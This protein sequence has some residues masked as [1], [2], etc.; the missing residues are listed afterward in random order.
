MGG[1]GLAIRNLIIVGN[2][3]GGPNLWSNGTKLKDL[4]IHV[5]FYPKNTIS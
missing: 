5:T 2:S 3:D 1:W 4:P